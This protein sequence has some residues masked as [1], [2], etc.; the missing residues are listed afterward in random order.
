MPAMISMETERDLSGRPQQMRELPARAVR[1]L[2]QV[3]AGLLRHDERGYLPL[4]RLRAGRTRSIAL[5][6]QLSSLSTS[7]GRQNVTTLRATSPRSKAAY[8]S[9]I[10]SMG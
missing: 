7:G 5:L 3:E 10:C 9:L 6:Q 8:A 2:T 4:W 1:D